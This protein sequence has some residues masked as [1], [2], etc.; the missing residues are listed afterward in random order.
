MTHSAGGIRDL[1]L[2]VIIVVFAVFFGKFKFPEHIFLTIIALT[3]VLFSLLVLVFDANL[4]GRLGWYFSIFN[5]I[6]IPNIIANIED[7]KTKIVLKYLIIW[8]TFFLHLYLIS[9]NYHQIVP[10]HLSY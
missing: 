5:I 1:F 9:R 8:F 7:Y 4:M 2:S 6:Y 3:Y 10:Y